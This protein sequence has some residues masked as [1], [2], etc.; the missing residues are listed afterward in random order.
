MTEDGDGTLSGGDAATVPNSGSFAHH[1][2][3]SRIKGFEEE[4]V[5]KREEFVPK[6]RWPDFIAQVFIHVGCLYGF[7]LIIVA[8]KLYTSLFGKFIAKRY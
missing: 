6:L 7:Y 4:K 5:P 1:R 8:A 2:R 3:G